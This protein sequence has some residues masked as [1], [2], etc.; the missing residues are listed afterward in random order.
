MRTVA[1]TLPTLPTLPEG[2]PVGIQLLG[3]K[4]DDALL[5]QLARVFDPPT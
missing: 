3:R 5:L 4:G 1:A 2:M